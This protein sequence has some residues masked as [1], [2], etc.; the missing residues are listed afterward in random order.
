MRSAVTCCC[1]KL[2]QHLQ[3][4]VGGDFFPVGSN[5]FEPI[6]NLGDRPQR[7]I[8]HSLPPKGQSNL[9]QSLVQGFLRAAR[10]ESCGRRFRSS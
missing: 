5:P 1:A 6:L 3:T 9:Q 8:F 7:A 2:T 10:F 4:L